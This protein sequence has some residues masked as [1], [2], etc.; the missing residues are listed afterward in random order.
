MADKDKKPICTLD[1]YGS[2]ILYSEQTT[3]HNHI[4]QH[5]DFSVKPLGYALLMCRCGNKESF[6]IELLFTLQQNQHINKHAYVTTDIPTGDVY[7]ESIARTTCHK[8]KHVG[9]YHEF[10]E[11]Y[12]VT[13]KSK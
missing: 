5:I 2:F 12:N 8:C 3:N 1:K 4:N 7:I 9:P 13:E 11:R 10:S 6:N